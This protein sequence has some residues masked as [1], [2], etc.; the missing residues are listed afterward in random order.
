M[1]KTL[2]LLF[3]TISLC[4]SLNAQRY[5]TPQFSGATRS[6]VVYGSNFTVLTLSVPT[7]ART[8]RQ[9]LQADIYQPTGDTLSRRPLVIFVPTSNF[10]PKSARLS[11]TGDRVDSVAVEMCTRFARLGYISASIDYRHGWN[12]IASTQTERVYTLI[13]AAYRGIQDVRAAVRYFKANANT[14][15]VDTNRIMLV[16]D[17]TGGYL[18]MGAATLDRYAKIFTTSLPQGKF[19]TLNAAG[20]VIPMVIEAVNGNINGT[21][22]AIAPAGVPGIPTGDTLNW[23]NNPANTSNI[24]MQVNLGGAVGD[25]TWVDSSSARSVS[26]A[27]PHDRNAPYRTGVLL[28]PIGNGQALPV[29]EVQGSHWMALR[30]DSFGVNRPFSRIVAARDPYRSLVAARNNAYGFGNTTATGLLPLI[31]RSLDD[32]APWQWWSTDTTR[33]QWGNCATCLAGNPGMSEAKARLYIDSIMTF[34]IPRACVGLNLPCAGV[35]TSTEDLLKDVKFSVAPNPAYTM[36]TLESEATNP[37]QAIEVYNMAGQ[38]VQTIKNVNNHQFQLQRNGL[39]AGVYIVKVKFE[40]GILSRKVVF[41][42]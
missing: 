29:V 2:L 14:L 37:M 4:M 6:T 33:Q 11:P 24:Q 18:T 30:A 3:A 5:L 22:L 40:G 38:A 36:V 23:P 31:G 7:I 10:L 26:I 39:P 13:N 28:V 32:S 21:N 12:P 15:R 16:G 17:G 35:V 8:S 9:P 42:N 19:T 41:E 27:C 25:F 1:K 34:V 20:A